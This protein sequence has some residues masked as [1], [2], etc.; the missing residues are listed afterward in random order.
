MA[1]FAK[2]F[3]ELKRN[4]V[5]EKSTMR[6]ESTMQP[7]GGRQQIQGYDEY[8][9]VATQ[10]LTALAGI[11]QCAPTPLALTRVCSIPVPRTGF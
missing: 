11:N 10:R 6:R 2:R 8:Y 9:G 3:S 7:R 5:H 4:H 1:E